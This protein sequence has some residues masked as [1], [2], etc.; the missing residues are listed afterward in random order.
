MTEELE[1]LH[2]AWGGIRADH[3][4]QMESVLADFKGGKLEWEQAHSEVQVVTKMAGM[5][6]EI[7][8]LRRH[9]ELD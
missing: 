6:S 4:Q 1:K 7:E 9:G 2:K 8:S 5:V 3:Q